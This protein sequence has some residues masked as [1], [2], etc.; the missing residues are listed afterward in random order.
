MSFG[1]L[2]RL[3]AA[4]CRRNRLTCLVWMP[5]V[6]PLRKNASMPLCQKLRIMS[7]VYSLTLRTARDPLNKSLSRHPGESR[8]PFALVF[9]GRSKWTS[10]RR[11]LRVLCVLRVSICGLGRHFFSVAWRLWI[12]ACA[13]MTSK[14]EVF[15]IPLMGAFP[16]ASERG[17][18]SLQGGSRREAPDPPLA[19][20]DPAY[21]FRADR[22]GPSGCRTGLRTRSP[23]RRSRGAVRRRSACRR[24]RGAHG[25][26]K[27]S[28]C[29]KKPTRPKPL[30]RRGVCTVRP[31]QRPSAIG[32]AGR[33]T[34]RAAGMRRGPAV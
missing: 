10:L 17:P 2:A 11:C 13:W 14:S 22:S 24:R 31:C 32:G 33:R 27:S 21:G 3:S 1:A 26:A 15:E 28:G 8:D 30:V 23:C 19:R 6:L 16:L 25:R 20:L 5:W 12:P 4:N 9:G 18:I 29:R 34:D 7:K